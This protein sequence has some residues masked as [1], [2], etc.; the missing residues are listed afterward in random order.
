MRPGPWLEGRRQSSG[1]TGER[2]AAR[3]SRI[4]RP[5]Q[6]SACKERHRQGRAVPHACPACCFLVEQNPPGVV[7]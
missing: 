4:V 5:R 6:V 1:F 2:V 3:R 7:I